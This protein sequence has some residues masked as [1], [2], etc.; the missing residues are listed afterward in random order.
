[1]SPNVIQLSSFAA[2]F[3]GVALACPARAD[4]LR[5]KSTFQEGLTLLDAKKHEAACIKFRESLAAE[6]SVG[7][8]LNVAMCST[9]EKKLA[10]AQDEYRALLV[11]NEATGDAE[12]RK[13]VD[14]RAREAMRSLGP[15]VPTLELSI[16]PAPEA[17]AIELD[18][19]PFERTRLG[20]P[21]PVDPGEHFIKIT[22][23]GFTP[24]E[25]RVTLRESERQVHQL[26]L[27]P[28]IQT[29]GLAEKD[30]A[31]RALAGW[32]TGGVGLAALALGGSLIGVASM[33]ASEIE[34][35]CGD[36]AEPPVCRPVSNA[37]AATDLSSEGR[38]L[39][40][41]GWVSIG[42]GAALTATGVVL[43]VTSLEP[44]SEPSATIAPFGPGGPGVTV[45]GSF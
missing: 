40:I 8:M 45:S 24:L 10:Q 39:E 16:S 23:Q 18:G 37:S 13:N 42:V 34:S 3:C 44:S 25:K 22:A 33:H 31:E 32:L 38:A 14:A 29:G 26:S 7:A 9:R 36:G 11:L 2:L 43:I 1:M 30:R 4:E 41:G 5:A 27:T 12:R 28:I 21:Q 17:L 35:L 19:K 6:P 20:T 15:R